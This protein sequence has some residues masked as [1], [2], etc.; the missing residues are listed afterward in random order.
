[1][2]SVI[3]P[4]GKK[5][6]GY[7]LETYQSLC[8]QT[9]K[10]WEWVLV[11]NG[12]GS[13]P[14]EIRIDGRVKVAPFTG[15]MDGDCYSIGKL[16]RF[17]CSHAEGDIIAE[18][19]ADD[20]LLPKCLEKVKKAI[21]DGAVFVYSNNADF[22]DG[23][24]KSSTFGS[25]YGWH[26]R[27]FHYKGHDLI[28]TISFPVTAHSLRY[29]F[30]SPDHIRAWSKSAY[31]EVGGHDASIKMGDDHDLMCRFYLKYGGEGFK[32]LDEVLYL[33]RKHPDNSCRV[34]NDVVQK[35]TLANYL[36]YSR[37][38][39]VRWS[40][41]NGLDMVDI[42][43]RK[44]EW[45][46]FKTVDKMPPANIIA[47]L[48]EPWPMAENSVGVLRASH[49]IEHLKN[50]IF[51]MNEA[52]RVLAPG[53]WMFIDVPSTDGRGAFQD[54]THVSFWNENALWYYTNENWARWIRPMF[55]GKFQMSRCVTW[56]PSKFEQD[57]NI[58]MVQADLICLKEPYESHWCGEKDI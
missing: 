45:A 6:E 58:P 30:W 25:Y 28:E 54:P 31:W 37:E 43:S 41:D 35:Q 40:R 7:L 5:H 50:P 36:K 49:I 16:K 32:F 9:Y 56:F 55:K 2:I 11:P 10:D 52:Y 33:Y 4:F 29:I 38:M 27:P 13:V 14:P 15:P 34:F 1:M 3:T 51:T 42:G 48:N 8:D 17:A 21:D 19:D 47:D 24:W 46:G 12:G 26:S 57:H 18:L 44:S 23:T 39:A 22:E 53:G 20:L